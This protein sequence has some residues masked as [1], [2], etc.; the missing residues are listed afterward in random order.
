[1][2]THKHNRLRG[3]VAGGIMAGGFLCAANTFAAATVNKSPEGRS[4]AITIPVVINNPQPTC[5]IRVR[6]SYAL[7]TLRMG[8][9]RHDPFPVTVSCSGNVKSALKARLTGRGGVLLPDNYRVA[10]STNGQT[11]SSVSGPFFWLLDSR[12][13]PIKF[14]GRN[15]DAFCTGRKQK[16]TCY[17][18]PVTSVNQDSLRGDKGVVDVVFNVIYPA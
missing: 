9:T 16:K 6:P 2:K 5:D 10:V 13:K 1:M 4:A 15:K 18:T 12:D 3:F 11:T 7:G 14:T 8:D 17:I